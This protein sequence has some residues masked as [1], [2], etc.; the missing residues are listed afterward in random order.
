MNEK[1]KSIIIMTA[2]A[3]TGI[4]L[5]FVLTGPFGSDK[6]KT[7]NTIGHFDYQEETGVPE[8]LTDRYDPSKEPGSEPDPNNV[9][10]TNYELLYDFLP[11]N[12]AGSV[13]IYAAEFLNKHGYGGYRE[14]TI[15]KDTVT[16]DE[17]YPRFI[18]TLDETDKYLEIR[19]RTDTK[20]FTFAL[21]N[22]IY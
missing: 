18:C 20:E 6:N 3:V 17:T 9:Y 8:D 14:L 7:Q 21:L 1:R 12:A 13:S 11:V 10:I 5:L 19:Y 22:E 4:G 16:S 15:L 2:A